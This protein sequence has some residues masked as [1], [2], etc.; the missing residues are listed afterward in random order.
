MI[1]SSHILSHRLGRGL[2]YALVFSISF[3]PSLALA[4]GMNVVTPPP[5]PPSQQASQANAAKKSDL[6][7]NLSKAM[8]VIS[9]AAGA[10]SLYKGAQQLACCSSGCTGSGV[11]SQ[12]K[13]NAID[14][15]SKGVSGFIKGTYQPVD[16]ERR[17]QNQ[18][19]TCPKLRFPFLRF[20]APVQVE[21]AG[22]CADALLS[23]A[24]GAMM[25]LSGTLGLMAAMKSG[26]NSNIADSNAGS[27]GAA[28]SQSMSGQSNSGAIKID[29][30]L[31]H[32][33][34]A[35]AV[36]GKFENQ[37]GIPREQFAQSLLNGEDPRTLLMNAPKSAMSA[38]D[39]NKG[40]AGAGL[41]TDAQKK[42]ALEQAG[43]TSIQTDLAASVYGA[44]AGAGGGKV[45]SY[46]PSK[47]ATLADL[48]ELPQ[49]PGSEEQAAAPVPLSPE[50]QA[51]ITAAETQK[52]LDG[53]GEQSLFE[54]VHLKYQEKQ[55]N[56]YGESGSRGV[57][58]VQGF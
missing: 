38:D 26:D 4:D 44:N 14:K 9:T 48:P 5:A 31:L 33:V 15:T 49:M 12:N 58:G 43:I 19:S 25:M 6:A 30:S 2:S 23:M 3:G 47:N 24:T 35:D 7:S 55:N 53:L 32:N 51:A 54:V 34:K 36:L 1:Y 41:L 56:I 18:A 50:L 11:D 46:K 13:K 52:K 21:A 20:L 10:L 17:F 22:G 8:G 40:Y 45:S 57:A 37:F 39:I 28:S 27:M 29:P 42:D 16:F